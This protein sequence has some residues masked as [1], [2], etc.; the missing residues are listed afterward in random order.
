[1]YI[2]YKK[3]NKYINVINA[4]FNMHINILIYMNFI[5]NS[6]CEWNTIFNVYK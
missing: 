2:T 4:S 6:I 5:L 3:S 1:M